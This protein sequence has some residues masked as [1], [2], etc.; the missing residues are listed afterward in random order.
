MVYDHPIDYGTFEGI[1]PDGYYGAGPVIIWDSG[2]IEAVGIDMDKGHPEFI[3][4]GN[5]LKGTSELT[6]LKQKEKDVSK[7]ITAQLAYGD[8]NCRD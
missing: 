3:L 2:N 7:A 4:N 8:F 1:I 6:E 5:K